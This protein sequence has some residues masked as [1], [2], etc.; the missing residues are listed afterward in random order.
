MDKR[1]KKGIST[2]V[3]VGLVLTI[4]TTAVLLGLVEMQGKS[5]ED[6]TSR[7]IC[8]QSVQKHADLHIRT[9]NP[10]SDMINCPAAYIEISKDKAMYEYRNRKSIINL[11]G[12]EKE[13]KQQ[14]QRIMA[15]E[16]YNC[17]NQ[18]GE[19]KKDL[20]G[21]PKKY[22]SVCSVFQFNDDLELNGYEFYTFLMQNKVPNRKLAEN[23]ITYFD[24]MQ[25]RTKKGTADPSTLQKYRTE[26]EKTLMDGKSPYAVVFVYAKSEPMIDNTM[27]FLN[28]FWE[29]SGGKVAVIGGAIVFAGGIA[30]SLTGIGAP[31]GISLAVIGASALR[32]VSTFDIQII[33][34]VAEAELKRDVIRDWTAFTVFGKYD[35][36]TLKELGCEELPINKNK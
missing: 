9:F 10:P 1:N 26:L 27:E 30:L 31:A 4:V 5:V 21:G 7:E 24:Y 15:D 6:V 18:F 23:G 35:E 14:V 11:K 34:G 2:E 16:I 36:G 12:T 22:C 32:A 33:E 19:G 20:F 29:S 13:K 28:K 8:R 3:L 17:W 25:G